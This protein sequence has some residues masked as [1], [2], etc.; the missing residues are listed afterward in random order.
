MKSKM[1]FGRGLVFVLAAAGLVAAC[2]VDDGGFIFDDEKFEELMGGSGGDGDGDGDGT[3]GVAGDGDG[4]GDGT[5][6]V[7]GDG[8]GDGDVGTGGGAP[9]CDCGAEETCVEGDCLPW[10]CEPEA[11]FCSR[12]AV[13]TC[14]DDGLS[15]T[16]KEPC[17]DDEYCDATEAICVVGVCAP[18]EPTCEGNVI[19]TCNADGSGYEAGGISCGSGTSCDA[20]MCQDHTCTPRATYC[21]GQE[22]KL[23][24]E[25]GLS[26]SVVDTCVDQTCVQS[27]SDAAC[28]GICEPGQTQCDGNSVQR[29][30]SEG[31]FSP[32]TACDSSS[33]YCVAGACTATP[34]SCYG[35]A[36]TCGRNA[37]DS[38][39]TSLP[40]AG[41]AFYLANDA[42]YEA[43]ISNFRLDKYEVTVG[44]FRKFVDAVVNGWRPVAGAGKHTHLNSGQG[45]SNSGTG[46]GYEPGWDVA[47]NVDDATHRMHASKASWDTSLT[48]GATATWTSDT[49]DNE[50]SPVGCVNWYQAAA[51]CIWD[52]G[53][54]PSEAEWNYAAA[55]GAEQ[56]FYPWS[57]PP[58]STSINCANAHYSECITNE[59]VFVGTLPA[60]D[61][62]FGQSDLSG[63]VAEWT[64]DWFATYASS[65]NNCTNATP[66]T[67]RIRRGGSVSAGSNNVSS[68]TRGSVLPETT[69]SS[70]GLRCARTP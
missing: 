24:A 57:N 26:S 41:G 50:T 52:G 31:Q 5:G 9:E 58:N 4:D 21:Q 33:P 54:L 69:V 22:V 23:C 38:C 19:R 35:L 47:W 36:S 66:G 64:L 46:G 20:A 44:R 68:V 56:R 7:A 48:C 18:S 17:A 29:C 55:G 37:D 12:N 2:S 25:N 14:A 10:E 40:V 39:C 51:F 53:F 61:G 32:G 60:G 49:G 63:N 45:L 30:G 15:S 67:N 6:G 11:D 16:E 62:R 13:L 8:D 42:D 43:E 27:G 70:G 65:C 59:L 3:G 28:Q 1:T 34:P